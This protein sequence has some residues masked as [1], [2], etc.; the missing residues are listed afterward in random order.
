MRNETH[1]F[2]PREILVGSGVGEIGLNRHRVKLTRL[3]EGEG[4][5]LKKQPEAKNIKPMNNIET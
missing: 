2:L 1:S 5:Y 4:R 3:R